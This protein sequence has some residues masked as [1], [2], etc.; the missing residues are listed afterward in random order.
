MAVDEVRATSAHAERFYT[1]LGDH[2]VEPLW[3][4]PSLLPPEPKSKAVPHVWRYAKM[5]ELLLEAGTVV[6]TEEAERRVLMLMNPGLEG[7][8]A[9]ATKLYAG[10]QL[11]LPG[12]VARAH[13]HAASALRFVIEGTGAFT[14]VDGERLV[15]HPGDLVFTPNWA[16]HD[17][18]NPTDEPVI[19]LDGLDLPLINALEANFFDHGDERS[20]ELTKPDNASA[21]LYGTGRLNPTWAA[22]DQPYSP[23]FAYAWAE[24]ERALAAVGSEA[25]A[26]PFDSV[27]FEY[28]NP[29]TGG[30]VLPTI[31]CYIQAL[32][33]GLH[34]DA[35]RHTA[36]S[37]YHVV[38][39]AGTT[40]VDGVELAWQER[41][42][43]AVPG[44]AAHEHVNEAGEAAIL[45]SF[46]TDPVVR[47]LGYHREERVDRQA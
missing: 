33:P 2:H 17:H 35:H 37:V 41:D 18:G 23:L 1:G 31:G 36:S 46:T 40:I 30:P 19:W 43:F 22:W 11:V 7:E 15:M 20:Q 6:D 38:R 39:G 42:T 13:R 14:A 8:A 10:L 4:R 34:T 26:S 12:E 28:T 32:P 9:A 16:W 25:A 44:W 45:F 5:R 27:I 3:R 21:R 24:T 47:A 29:V